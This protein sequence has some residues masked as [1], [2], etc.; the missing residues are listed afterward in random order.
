MKLVH[1]SDCC[2]F[3]L[4]SIEFDYVRLLNCSITERSIAFDWQFFLGVRLSSITEPNRTQSSDWVRLGS[5]TETSIS[6]A[7]NMS[8]FGLVVSCKA[9]Q[10][11]DLPYPIGRLTKTSTFFFRKYYNAS[12]R[13]LFK[14]KILKVRKPARRPCKHPPENWSRFKVRCLD[15]EV[16]CDWSN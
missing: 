8:L 3:R 11:S 15:R 5:I 10:I 4:W 7:G 2:G 16:C 6:Y 13:K 9:C 1:V 12:R 14:S